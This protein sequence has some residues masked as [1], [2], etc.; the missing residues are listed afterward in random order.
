[1]FALLT[2]NIAFDIGIFPLERR[3]VNLYELLLFIAY[4]GKQPAEFVNNESKPP[5]EVDEIFRPKAILNRARKDNSDSADNDRSDEDTPNKESRLLENLLLQA[6]TNH[7]HP[8]ALYYE[9][10]LLSIVR[11]PKTSKDMPVIAIKLV[12]HKGTNRKPKP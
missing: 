4:T 10:I 1:M 11:H 12:H 8:K 6:V 5:K 3:R 7:G 9:D 2:F